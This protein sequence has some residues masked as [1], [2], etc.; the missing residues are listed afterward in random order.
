MAKFEHSILS[1]P[2]NSHS[3]S[4]FSLVE[5]TISIGIMAFALVGIY[6]LLPTGLNVFRQA[7]NTSVSSQIIQRVLNE[8]QETDFNQLT[9]GA[10]AADDKSFLKK[11][12]LDPQTGSVRWFDDQANELNTAAGAIYHVNTRVMPTTRFPG[13]TQSNVNMATITVQV[14]N[15]PGNATLALGTDSNM[16]NLWN[17]AFS[18]QTAK[19][20]PI[21]TWSAVVARN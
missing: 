7:L 12:P 17:G 13:A 10:N 16:P 11:N 18:K 2:K 15:N 20:V 4:A 6:G 8:V 3:Q 5:V 14:A 21:V 9:L 1:R 19:I